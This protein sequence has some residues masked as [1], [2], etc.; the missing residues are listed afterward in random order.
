MI[1]IIL[2]KRNIFRNKIS[3]TFASSFFYSVLS[4]GHQNDHRNTRTASY[5]LLYINVTAAT[6][7]MPGGF[8]QEKQI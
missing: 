8:N 6:L 2:L 5:M 4:L 3:K 1:N 7:W